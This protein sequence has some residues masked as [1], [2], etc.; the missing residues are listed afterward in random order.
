MKTGTPLE[1]LRAAGARVAEARD[2]LVR[3]SRENLD[4]CARLLNEARDL[5]SGVAPAAAEERAAA[6]DLHTALERAEALA[7]QAAAFYLECV[8]LGD[9]GSQDY[10]P[11]GA[12]QAAAPPAVRKL[13]EG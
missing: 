8:R 1:R 7:R 13:A 4:T 6:A 12:A 2:L 11:G 3:P 10:T 5:A 9:A